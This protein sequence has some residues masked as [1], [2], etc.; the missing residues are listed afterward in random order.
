MA[1]SVLENRDR[2]QFL[3][4]KRE[5]IRQAAAWAS[6]T[7]VD[8]LPEWTGGER[9]AEQ[10]SD[11]QVHVLLTW[12]WAYMELSMTSGGSGVD[13]VEDFYERA[14]F[15]KVNGN[16]FEGVTNTGTSTSTGGRRRGDE[17]SDL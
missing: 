17:A 6:A 9:F 3:D 14:S 11:E 10:C 1:F 4:A 7:I 15:I 8:W 16:L 2:D 13:V 5:A 12:L